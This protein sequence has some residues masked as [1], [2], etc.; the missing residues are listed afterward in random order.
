MKPFIF[1]KN[2][3]T[4]YLCYKACADLELPFIWT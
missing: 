1:G 4:L 2:D 3:S